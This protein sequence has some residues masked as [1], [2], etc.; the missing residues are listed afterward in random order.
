MVALSVSFGQ[1]GRQKKPVCL[2]TYAYRSQGCSYFVDKEYRKGVHWLE[3][4][5]LR[6]TKILQAGYDVSCS[7]AMRSLHCPRTVRQSLER[8]VYESS[9]TVKK[10][11]EQYTDNMTAT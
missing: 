8:F 4:L 7:V 1:R 11:L 5:R 10:V 3:T 9:T 2:Y 6:R